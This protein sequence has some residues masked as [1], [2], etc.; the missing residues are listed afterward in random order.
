MHR[1]VSNKT[2]LVAEIPNLT[3][4]ESVIIALWQGKIPFSILSDRFCEQQ[5]F[6]YLLA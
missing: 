3:N 4:K 2:N 6:P 1:T 5:A